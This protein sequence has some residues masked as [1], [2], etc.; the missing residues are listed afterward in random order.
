MFSQVN[1]KL[2]AIIPY[3]LVKS[4]VMEMGLHKYT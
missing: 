3:T 4:R 1:G 2:C